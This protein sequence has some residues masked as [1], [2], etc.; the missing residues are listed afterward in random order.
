MRSS[1][2][3]VWP[4]RSAAS[5]TR[6]A[7]MGTTGAGKALLFV[8]IMRTFMGCSAYGKRLVNTSESIVKYY[9]I[10]SSC[11]EQFFELLLNSFGLTFRRFLCSVLH[12]YMVRHCLPFHVR[13]A[14]YGR[15]ALWT[16]S[17]E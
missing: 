4:A 11:Q 8:A 17:R 12:S 10:H 15:R 16:R 1:T 6:H 2:L 7:P 13:T 3:T 5:A 9:R 14:Q